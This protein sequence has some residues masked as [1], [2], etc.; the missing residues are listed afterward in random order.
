VDHPNIVCLRDLYDAG[1]KFLFVMELVTGGELFDRI[2]EKGCYT[3]DHAK[4][5]VKKIVSGVAYLHSNGIA[6]RDLKPENLLLKSKDNDFEVKIADFGL[7]SFIDSQKMM[8][9]A[10]G[11]P[12]YVA[13]EVLK[14][15]GG[16]DKEV[17]LWSVGVITYILLCGFPPFHAESVRGL[18]QVVIKGQYD[19]PSPY[20][21]PISPDA[22]DFI[23]QLLTTPERRMNAEQ[24]LQHNWLKTE[25]SKI[26]LPAFRERMQSYVTARK[27]ESMEMMLEKH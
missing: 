8:Q 4:Q 9:T 12:A 16:Y 18:L 15:S 13:P 7:S 21:D 5:L 11:T 17:D 26:Q 6:H 3:E 2:V 27:K 19:F 1:E 24:T 10:C 14:S 23:S 20:W 25:G 22:T